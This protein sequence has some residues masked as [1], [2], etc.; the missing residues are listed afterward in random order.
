MIIVGNTSKSAP[1]HLHFLKKVIENNALEDYVRLDIGV[2]I[3]KLLDLMSK[4]K[5][6]LHTMIG[7]P[8][9]ISVVEAMS[10]GLIPVVPDVGGSSEFVPKQYHYSTFKQAVEIIR[11]GLTRSDWT[12]KN[13]YRYTKSERIKIS[14]SV[15]R[16]SAKFYKDNLR[17][18]ITSQFSN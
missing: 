5:V 12:G 16:F 13:N 18:I 14:N 4:S 6:Y 1:D 15:V 10:A 8:F 11:K 2:H 17:N 3:E 9:G 7:G